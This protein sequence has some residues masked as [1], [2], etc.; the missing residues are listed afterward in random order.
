MYDTDA[1]LEFYHVEHAERGNENINANGH[2]VWIV[3]ETLCDT[4][5]SH[6]I[7]IRIPAFCNMSPCVLVHTN[8]GDTAG[9]MWR[10]V[11]Y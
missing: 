10:V 1:N 5:V 11:H 3:T 7:L 6:R 9:F 8:N 4:A 2:C